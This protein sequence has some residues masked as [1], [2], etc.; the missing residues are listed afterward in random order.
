MYNIIH[1]NGNHN[2]FVFDIDMFPN[3]GDSK[4]TGVN[5]DVYK[6]RGKISDFLTPP[7]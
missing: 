7:P 2:K 6:N 3:E 4:V 1:C 5:K